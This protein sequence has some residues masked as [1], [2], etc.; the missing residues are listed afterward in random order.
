MFDVQT[1]PSVLSLW[2]KAD[3]SHDCRLAPEESAAW[4][5]KWPDRLGLAF[6]G[7]VQQRHSLVSNVDARTHVNVSRHVRATIHMNVTIFTGPR[8][9]LHKLMQALGLQ[10][11]L[12]VGP[13]LEMSRRVCRP[14]RSTNPWLSAGM[15]GHGKLQRI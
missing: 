2:S 14:N 5:Q 4:S 12:E 15:F 10:A 6:F 9:E 3:L 1:R 8:H 11:T 13:Q 7:S